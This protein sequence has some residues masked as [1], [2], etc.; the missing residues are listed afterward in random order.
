MAPPDNPDGKKSK[1]MPPCPR[2]VDP[3]VHSAYWQRKMDEDEATEAAAARSTQAA[4]T[5]TEA[6]RCSR[7]C[8][9][10]SCRASISLDQH[11]RL[12]APP[13]TA[14]DT[15]AASVGRPALLT[16][17]QHFTITGSELEHPT[18][19]R[20]H[21][22]GTNSM[23]PDR[24]STQSTDKTE[25]ASCFEGPT[26]LFHW[27]DAATKTLVLAGGAALALGALYWMGSESSSVSTGR[28]A[29]DT[30]REIQ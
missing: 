15:E 13:Y 22:A 25:S 28:L 24:Q 1:A 11:T 14:E 5:Q 30:T 27:S 10:S 12:P 20:Q 23:G 8:Q 16:S 3:L 4:S 9:C 7:L 21:F 18:I 26:R 19:N 17:A 2:G 6:F 29:L